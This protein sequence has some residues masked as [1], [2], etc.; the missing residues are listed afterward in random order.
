MRIL[1]NTWFSHFAQSELDDFRKLAAYMLSMTD[2]Q[3]DME[4]QAG[5]YIEI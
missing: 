4:I 2:D 5:R 1:K 3:I